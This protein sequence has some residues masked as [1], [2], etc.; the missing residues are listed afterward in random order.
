MKITFDDK[1]IAHYAR[2]RAEVAEFRAL[3]A[4][5]EL[6]KR[7]LPELAKAEVAAKDAIQDIPP[8]KLI[9]IAFDADI[10]AACAEIRRAEFVFAAV[11]GST[12]RLTARLARLTGELERDFKELQQELRW[13]VKAVFP[14]PG[15]KDEKLTTNSGI[16]S[17]ECSAAISRVVDIEGDNIADR[18]EALLSLATEHGL[19]LQEAA[20]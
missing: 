8:S 18:A 2:M 1:E 6:G 4:E 14:A 20:L 11:K 9:A 7:T 17:P 3:N 13:K 16:I 15:R 19:Q 12:A 10:A 5:V